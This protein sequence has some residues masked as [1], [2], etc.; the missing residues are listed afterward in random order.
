MKKRILILLS[1]VAMLQAGWA[2]KTMV[3][4]NRPMVSTNRPMVS[5]NRP[6]V[7]TDRLVESIRQRYTEMKESIATHPGH[8][9][10]DGADFGQYYHLEA[11]QWLPATGGHVENTYLYWDNVAEDEDEIYPRHYVKFVTKKF[12]YAARNYYQEFLY[13]PDGHVAFIYAYDPMPLFDGDENGMQ[14]EF[15]FY[16]NKGRLLK[17]IVK[18]KRYDQQDFQQVWSGTALKPDYQ[19]LFDD[20]MSVS[21][22]LRELFIS[23]ENEAYM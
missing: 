22:S 14:Y 11:R 6:M 8:N 5:T 20:Y 18:S 16:L 13:D 15:R 4:T 9:V 10:D 2:Q 12:N 17:A 7:S 21:R 1:L 23:I 19:T 3:S